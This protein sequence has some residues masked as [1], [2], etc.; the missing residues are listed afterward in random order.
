MQYLGYVVEISSS[1]ETWVFLDQKGKILEGRIK[2][3]ETNRKG[4]YIRDLCGS[5]NSYKKAY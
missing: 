2:E 1:L 3:L 4:K 5:L